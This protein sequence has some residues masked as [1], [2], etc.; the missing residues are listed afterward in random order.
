MNQP[1]FT[2]FS[3]TKRVADDRGNLANTPTRPTP[4]R[5]NNIKQGLGAPMVNAPNNR[6]IAFPT[7]G[8]SE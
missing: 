8:I 3:L 4:I 2:R 6:D 1:T 5:G 7:T